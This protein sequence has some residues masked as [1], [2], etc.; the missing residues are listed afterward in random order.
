MNN[1]HRKHILRMSH[2]IM[3]NYGT[4]GRLHARFISPN[5]SLIKPRTC[6]GDLTSSW[7]ILLF[8][9]FQIFQAVYMSIAVVDLCCVEDWPWSVF[10][11]HSCTDCKSSVGILIE[12]PFQFFTRTI[13]L[14]V[15]TWLV[16]NDRKFLVGIV[17]FSHTNQST[18]LLHE[19]ATIRTSQPNRLS[20]YAGDRQLTKEED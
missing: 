14:F 8:S 18:I 17:F 3:E 9:S 2:F 6:T 16:V 5:S 10:S 7:K 12:S 4:S 19:S 13:S 20:V 15:W 1:Q 11:H